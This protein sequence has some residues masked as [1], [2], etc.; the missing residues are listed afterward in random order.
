MA[1]TIGNKCAK[2][3][4]K[5]TILVQLI[6]ENVVTCFFE[7]QC[8]FYMTYNSLTATIMENMPK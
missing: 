4:C 3:F 7:T 8:I 1:Y 5:W 6:V 2:N